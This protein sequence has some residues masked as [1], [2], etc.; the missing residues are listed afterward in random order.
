MKKHKG[1]IVNRQHGYTMTVGG[2]GGDI[3]GSCFLEQHD[4][5]HF[6]ETTKD[7]LFC[8]KINTWMSGLQETTRGKYCQNV[9]CETILA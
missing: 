3:L 6:N 2:W 1:V 5:L 4:D 7:I 8:A 9:L